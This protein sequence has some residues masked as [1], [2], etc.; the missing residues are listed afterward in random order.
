MRDFCIFPFSYSIYAH[1]SKFSSHYYISFLGFHSEYQHAHMTSRLLWCPC[2]D[3][4]NSAGLTL[5]S[6]SV[7]Q[8]Q[9]GSCVSYLCA[10]PHHL[11]R[12][13][14]RSLAWDGS[15]LLASLLAHHI[16]QQ[17]LLI[18]FFFS[19]SRIYLPLPNSLEIT[20]VQGFSA[21]SYFVPKCTLSNVWYVFDCHYLGIATG[22]QWV[23]TR[24][25]AK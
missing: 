11:L 7:P 23:E 4:S 15:L 21:R 13:S 24:D 19:V 2:G 3:S 12:C 9:S 6:W 1:N 17:A 8:D 22:I 18:F 5:N 14:I 20:V 16:H 10:W 25:S